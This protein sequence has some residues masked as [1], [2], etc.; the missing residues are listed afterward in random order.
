MEQLLDDVAAGAGGLG[1]IGAVALL[2]SASGAIGALRHAVNQAWGE[3]DT[4]P[5]APGKALD[6]GLTL[7]VGPILIAGLGLSLSGSLARTI[8]DHPWIV[9]AAQFTVT[10]LAPVALLLLVLVGLFRVLPAEPRRVRAAWLG[11][12][13]A[14]TG[15]VLVQL[16]A[17]RLLL[18]VR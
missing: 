8:G 18:R 15:V 10:E 16:G 9:A 5:Y 17:D 13:V 12:L 4:L 3:H 1:W 2:Y 7:I 6:A 11:G 14:L